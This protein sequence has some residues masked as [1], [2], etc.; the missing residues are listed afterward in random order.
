[1]RKIMCP[2]QYHY[3]SESDKISEEKVLVSQ[4]KVSGFPEKGADQKWKS[5]KLPG[6]FWIAV[7]FRS[8]NTSREVGG[9]LPG[10]PG[11]FQKR[12]GA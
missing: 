11:T 10:S 6:N 12:G 1:M 4:E 2:N 9:E 7:K 8:D 5:G 3:E